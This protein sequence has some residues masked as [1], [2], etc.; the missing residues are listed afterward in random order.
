MIVERKMD[1]IRSILKELIEKK[2]VH[3][4]VVTN[5]ILVDSHPLFVDLYINIK[6]LGCEHKLRIAIDKIVIEDTDTMDIMIEI[7]SAISH[8]L[9]ITYGAIS[10]FDEED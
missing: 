10:I 4:I 2:L 1:F 9:G 3:G 7:L 5:I 8:K 6:R